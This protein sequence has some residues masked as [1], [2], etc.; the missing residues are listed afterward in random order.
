[1]DRVVRETGAG[2]LYRDLDDLVGQLHGPGLDAARVAMARHR[3][4]FTFDT[5]VGELER[6]LGQE[7]GQ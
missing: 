7:H 2:L 6:V 4:G 3:H 1:M 5:H